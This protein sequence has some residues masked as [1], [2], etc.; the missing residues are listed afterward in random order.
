[1]NKVIIQIVK[2]HMKKVVMM[3]LLV[4]EEEDD[5]YKER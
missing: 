1:M 3:M 5:D 4:E 2:A